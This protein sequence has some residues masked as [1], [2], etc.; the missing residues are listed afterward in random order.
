MFRLVPLAVLV[1]S[2]KLVLLMLKLGLL[3]IGLLRTLRASA[4]NVILM[5]CSVFSTMDLDNS[6]LTV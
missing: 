6:R 2:P 1:I 5:L 3:Q 4:R